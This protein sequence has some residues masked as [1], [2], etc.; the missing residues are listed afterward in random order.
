MT[1]PFLKMNGLG[2]DFVVIETRSAPFNPTAEEV[3]AIADRQTGIGCDQLIVVDP[4]DAADARVRFWN[5]S[6]EEVSACGNGAR[7]VGW[8]LMQASGKD[9]AV[10][11]TLA[12]QLIA[13]RAGDRLVSVDMGE[14][15]LDWQKIPLSAQHDTAALEVALQTLEPRPDL[16][17]CPINVPIVGTEDMKQLGKREPADA[18]V[19][20]RSIRAEQMMIV[21]LGELAT[22]KSVRL[23]NVEKM[24][25]SEQ[26]SLNAKNA[27][28][29]EKWLRRFGDVKHTSWEMVI[30]ADQRVDPA[31]VE[32]EKFRPGIVL[33]RTFVYSHLEGKVVCAGRVAARSSPLLRT[34][35]VTT[36]DGK[37]WHLVFDLENETYREAARKL[38]AAGPV[39]DDAPSPRDAGAP[40]DAS[41]DAR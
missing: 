27:A 15:G 26:S 2:N 3:R 10:I 23:E 8:L 5:A 12:G 25:A 7:C 19:N 1:H 11:E 28:D 40:K 13:A 24:L 31:I 21:K 36:K 37:D 32:Q 22:T 20:W 18:D 39:R 35:N 33:G 14:P 34:E 16:G 30:V 38:S 4:S 17:P 9:E 29:V 41:R 6:G